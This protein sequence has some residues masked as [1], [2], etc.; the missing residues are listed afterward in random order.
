MLVANFLMFPNKRFS[1]LETNNRKFPIA[2]ICAIFSLKTM[3]WYIIIYI[4]IILIILIYLKGGSFH[5]GKLKMRKWISK[6]PVQKK[7]NCFLITI[8]T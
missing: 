3:N 5:I 2:R 8:N 1:E 4:H 6:S 7:L